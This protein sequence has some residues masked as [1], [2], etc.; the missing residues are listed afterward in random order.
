LAFNLLAY[1]GRA[2]KAFQ[3]P[4]K[5]AAMTARP[6]EPRRRSRAKLVAGESAQSVKPDTVFA[7]IACQRSGTHL[8]R[9]ILNSSPA[10]AVLGETLSHAEYSM[11]WHNFVRNSPDGCYPPHTSRDA[12][13]LFDHY[14]HAIERDVHR[15]S[16]CYGGP[17]PQ[18]KR[19]GLDIKYEHI[20]CVAP[21]YSDLRSRPFLFDYF[22]DRRVRVVHLVRR[23]IVQT[24]ISII[25]ANAR[26][27]WH[28]YDGSP[29]PGRYRISPDELFGFIHWITGE[30]EEFLRLSQDLSM[31]TYFYEDLVEDMA[32]V[33]ASGFFREDSTLSSISTFLKVPNRFRLVPGMS[34]VINRPYCEILENYD[35]LLGAIKKSAY[36]EFAESL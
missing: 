10:I 30:R 18:L 16:D 8:L 31:Q 11:C 29:I 1:A 9:H 36:S 26:K 2:L 28:N 23:N 15:N 34:K 14:V 32:S 22:R 25:I 21:L 4:R 7:V 5:S 33:D 27:I 13:M 12:T 3:A 17:K 24:A 19:I 35:E 6:F 20:R